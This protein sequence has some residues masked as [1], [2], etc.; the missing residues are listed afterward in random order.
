MTKTF[1]VNKNGKI[2]FTKDELK[3]LL[4]EVYM[5]GRNS[6]TYTYTTPWVSPY[7]WTSTS[8]SGTISGS[9]TN[10]SSITL[11]NNAEKSIK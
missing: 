5:E 9:S 4:D 1:T 3:K 2:E 10:S 11:T 8:T 6:T 7:V